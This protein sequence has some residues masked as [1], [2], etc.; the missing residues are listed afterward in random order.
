MVADGSRATLEFRHMA[1]RD[2][3]VTNEWSRANPV[4]L[5]SPGTTLLS[6]VSFIR[7]IIRDLLMN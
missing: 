1:F 3:S 7:A 5:N 4:R 2:A 6:E